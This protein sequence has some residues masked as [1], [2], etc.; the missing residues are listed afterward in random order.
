MIGTKTVNATR[1][2]L[3]STTDEEH[4]VLH[5]LDDYAAHVSG[6]NNEHRF[7]DLEPFIN[8]LGKHDDL[9]EKLI[10]LGNKLEKAECDFNCLSEHLTVIL[11]ESME[12]M[13]R[14]DEL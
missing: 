6:S 4:V 14:H 1:S 7:M 10:D 9:R 13:M 3:P 12:R 5:F 8:M 11:N 2:R